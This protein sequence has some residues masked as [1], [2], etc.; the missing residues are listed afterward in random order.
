MHW[1]EKLRAKAA[2]PGS[3]PVARP[4]VLTS[5][6][7]GMVTT[8]AGRM[9]N[10]SSNNYLDLANAP[11]V[12]AAAAEALERYG[13][14]LASVRFL[15]GTHALHLE[16]ER[17]T[18]ELLHADDCIAFG[19]CFDANAGIF[20]ALLDD[21]DRIVS[22]ELNH[23]SIIDGV[24]LAKASRLRYRHCDL[25]DLERL[26]RE[27]PGTGITMI[28]TDGVFSM[29]GSLAP[30]ADLVRLAGRYGA[31]LMVDDSHGIGTLGA[32]GRG[33][34]EH[35]D[36]L[37]QV[38]I[39]TG[40]YGKALGGAMGGFVAAGR[41]IIELLRARSRPYLFSNPIPASLAA[42]VIAAMKLMQSEP[43]RLG[44]LRE[45]TR[46][47]RT[48]LAEFGFDVP[49]GVHPIAPVML[50]DSHRTRSLVAHA[51]SNGVL[52]S[53]IEY[54]VVPRGTERIRLQVSAGHTLEQ[55]ST[56][57]QVLARGL[58]EMRTA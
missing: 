22:D 29:D 52:V 33:T 54:P 6:A 12:R 35:F 57:I 49:A 5:A 34:A 46:F 23:A 44:R 37:G 15:S 2:A 27:G 17:A 1:K 19:S 58:G 40:T 48:Q 39:I 16:L 11:P 47:L 53:G 21:G 25:E 8:E 55:L 50:R 4:M 45:S 13:L 14:G 9:V 43:L 56:V 32:T 28:V 38:D 7:G 42:G 51:R 31:L 41:E 26:L 10:M 36:M 3:R 24:R 20:E 30:L 18:R